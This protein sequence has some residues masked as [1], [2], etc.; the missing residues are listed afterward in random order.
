MIVYILR[1]GSHLLRILE[2]YV[3]P[4]EANLLLRKHPTKPGR[5]QLVLL[6]HGLYKELDDNFRRN[7]C[8]LWRAIICSNE[9]DIRK[10]CT[11][12]NAGELFT[13]LAAVLTMRSWD[14]ITS[15]DINRLILSRSFRRMSR[16]L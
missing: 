2:I 11:N 12:L 9:A 1:D 13:I 3:D 4:H 10:Y 14:D 15:D 6:D 16:S 8:R 7:Y 5:P